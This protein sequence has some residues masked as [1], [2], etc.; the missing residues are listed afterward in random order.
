MPPSIAFGPHAIP[1]GAIQ[2]SPS[3]SAVACRWCHALSSGQLSDDGLVRN[4]WLLVNRELSGPGWGAGWPPTP[5]QVLGQTSLTPKWY[6][7][8]VVKFFVEVTL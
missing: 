1:E 3:Q 6:G 8:V 7:T 2:R 5:H 4:R